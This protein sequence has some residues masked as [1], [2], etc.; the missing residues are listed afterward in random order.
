MLRPEGVETVEN[1]VVAG[2]K[3]A[4][5]DQVYETGMPVRQLNRKT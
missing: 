5:V 4:L 2:L 3:L 1:N